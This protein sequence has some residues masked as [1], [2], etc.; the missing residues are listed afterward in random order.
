MTQIPKF[1]LRGNRFKMKFRNFEFSFWNDNAQSIAMDQSQSSIMGKSYVYLRQLLRLSADIRVRWSFFLWQCSAFRFPIKSNLPPFNS[2]PMRWNNNNNKQQNANQDNN[3][4]PKRQR[5][6]T[7]VRQTTTT[8]SDN[9]DH[10]QSTIN[11][12]NE[13]KKSKSK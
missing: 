11:L 13:R 1:R 5:T 9:D 10:C 3:N 8:T 2:P 4:Y 12:R 6:T 7:I